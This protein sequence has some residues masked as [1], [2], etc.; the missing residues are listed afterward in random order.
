MLQSSF[1]K[2]I[3]TTTVLIVSVFL[4]ACQQPNVVAPPVVLPVQPPIVTPPVGAYPWTVWTADIPTVPPSSTGVTYYVDGAN[5]I[6][7]NN[8]TSANT[9]FKTIAKALTMIAAGDTVLIRK[10]LYRESLISPVSGTKDKPIT[11]GSYG[12]GEVILDGSNKTGIW[13]KVSGSIWKTK[14]SDWQAGQ[15]IE[16]I[17]VVVNDIVLKQ[18]RQGQN[19]STAPQ[20]GLTGVKSGNGKWFNGTDIV[21]DMGGV[22]PNTADIVVPKL[23]AD[24]S[25]VF[26]YEK[27]YLVFKGLTIRGSGSNGIWGYGS[28]I[29]I[30][31]C[32][33]KFNG[34]AAVAFIPNSALG[35]ESTDNSVLNSNIY[36][37]VLINFPR[38][39]NGY[40]EAGGSWPGAVSWSGNYRPIAR[41]NIVHMNGGEG[42]A[43]YGSTAG[44]LN[45]SAIFEQN[46]VF[47][48]WSVN[49]YFD[50]QP[51]NIA[52]NNLIYNHPI[53][54]NPDTNDFIFSGLNESYPYNNIWKF[55]VGIGLGDEQNSSEAAANNAANLANSQV[56]NNII[57]GHRL[58]IYDYSEGALTNQYHALK[59]TI[60]ANNTIIMAAAEFPNSSAA[61]IKLQDNGNRNVGNIIANNVIYGFNQDALMYSDRT[62]ALQGITLSNN[63]YYSAATKPF[64]SWNG[65][66]LLTYDL[67]AWKTNVNSESN[68]QF[69]DPLLENISA[70]QQ[71]NTKFFVPTAAQPKVGSPVLGAG[72]AQGFAA[73]NFALQP[74]TSWNAGAY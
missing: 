72:I 66:D 37:N 52:R 6:N 58:S 57:I 68:S 38:G 59:N 36:Q 12:D 54:L 45:G 53:D 27:E 4:S 11:F 65:K 43:S 18:V 61:G 13:T 22:D 71:S 3:S 63:V 24:Q 47:D 46:V 32:N 31:H 14:K 42:I 20:E 73:V 28:H 55:S 5:G 2:I 60:I 1:Y 56:Y 30:E 17:A 39:N 35:V 23:S 8:G 51:N 19:G 34:K 67:A 10:G 48:N 21:A 49:M 15:N 44:K 25:H 74:R 69:K 26:F 7:T 50:N 16:P 33:I 40:V 41:G 9:A 64:T 70:F 29:T 62:G